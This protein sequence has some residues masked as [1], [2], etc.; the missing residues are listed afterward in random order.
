LLLLFVVTG[1]VPAAPVPKKPFKDYQRLADET[2]WKF[3]D[4]GDF[5][6]RLAAELKGFEVTPVAKGRGEYTVRIW[7]GKDELLIWETIPARPFHQRNDILFYADFH[8]SSSGCSVVAFDLKSKKQ[9]W[10]CDLKGLGGIDHSKYR[11]EVRME[12]LDDDTLRVFG[13]ESAGK[14]VEIVDR[15]TG[16]TV[17]HKV[18]NEKK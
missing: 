10:K 7:K 11:N 16:T 2:E 14:Y 12:L 13:K 5:E 17:G 6:A 18:F 9:L 4:L 1:T 15:G 8:P 3:E